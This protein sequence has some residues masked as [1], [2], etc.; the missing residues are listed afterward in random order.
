LKK[1]NEVANSF[2]LQPAPLND[3]K[4]LRDFALGFSALVVLCFSGLLPWIFSTPVPLWPF[5]V[6]AILIPLGLV[7]PVSIYPAYRIWLVVASILGW[8]NTRII[9]F[10]AF[11]V[12]IFP[13]G[14]VLRGLHKLQ[15]N[16]ILQRGK[17]HHSYWQRRE[18]SPNKNNLK[19]P[20]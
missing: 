17:T 15:Y 20:F 12:M 5:Y 19:E 10:A 4:A 8:V 6:A 3:K 9:M 2:W 16:T 11:F 18:H 14:L 13:I 7:L 1:S